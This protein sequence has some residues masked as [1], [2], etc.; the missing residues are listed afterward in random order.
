MEIGEGGEMQP[1]LMVRPG[2]SGAAEL[3]EMSRAARLG[4]A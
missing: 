2:W 3:W 4:S 1:W